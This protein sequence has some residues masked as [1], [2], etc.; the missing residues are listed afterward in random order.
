MLAIQISDSLIQCLETEHFARFTNLKRIKVTNSMM[1][2][3]FCENSD[4]RLLANVEHLNFTNNRITQLGQDIS[5]L[6]HLQSLDLSDNLLS[7][8]LDQ[9]EFSVLPASLNIL[10]LRQNI[11]SCLPSLT[12][13]HAWARR[14]PQLADSLSDVYC[15]IPNSHQIAPLVQV[16]SLY[17]TAINPDCSALC[18]CVLHHFLPG[19]SY[20]FPSYTVIVNCSHQVSPG[21]TLV[22][23]RRRGGKDEF[24]E[25]RGWV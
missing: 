14:V 16:M 20:Y 7:E 5:G 4:V 8:T 19:P 25:I 10:E 17:R 1:R 15:R 12:W 13:L 24:S 18:S 21:N 23:F 3:L 6:T 2:H 22:S 11:F 9:R